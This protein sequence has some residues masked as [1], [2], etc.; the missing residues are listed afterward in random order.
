VE[1]A[2]LLVMLGKR[3]KEGY[4]ARLQNL[5]G[6]RGTPTELPGTY[7]AWKLVSAG[8]DA[9]TAAAKYRWAAIW[10]PVSV[11][12]PSGALQIRPRCYYLSGSF[13]VLVGWR[14]SIAGPVRLTN[15]ETRIFTCL[16]SGSLAS[17][18]QLRHSPT[19]ASLTYKH[20]DWP[21]SIL[22]TGSNDE[23]D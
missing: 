12:R 9:T 4:F 8:G 1:A 2:S 21:P 15:Y 23:D 5:Y 19:T 18:H 16:T 14:V 17:C 6:G 10:I 13:I 7:L 20:R 3:R 22:D 11:V